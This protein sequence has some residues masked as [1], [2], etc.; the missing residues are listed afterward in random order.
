MALLAGNGCFI[1]YSDNGDIVAKSKTAGDDEMLK[2]TCK[3]SS[4]PSMQSLWDLSVEREAGKYLHNRG[5]SI[6]S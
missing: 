1:A 3:L 4:S 2:V 6:V 5:H